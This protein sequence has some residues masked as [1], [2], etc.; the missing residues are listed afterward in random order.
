M[1]TEKHTVRVNIYGNEYPIKSEADPE[2]IKRVARYVDQKMRE[3]SQKVDSRSALEVAILAALNITDEL[4]QEK[5]DKDKTVAEVE[6][7]TAELTEWLEKT[8]HSL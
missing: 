8:L 3:I 6:D 5:A 1:E 2:Y 4:M 7:R